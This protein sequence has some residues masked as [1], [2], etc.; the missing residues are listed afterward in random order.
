VRTTVSASPLA[1]SSERT[2]NLRSVRKLM[3]VTP[4]IA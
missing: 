4:I 1:R 3:A 2:A